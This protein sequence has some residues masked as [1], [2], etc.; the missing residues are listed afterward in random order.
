MTFPGPTA[1][2]K[3]VES[4]MNT[5][6]HDGDQGDTSQGTPPAEAVV[7]NENQAH[8][9]GKHPRQKKSKARKFIRKG[10]TAYKVASIVIQLFTLA[11]ILV[12]TGVTYRMWNVGRV[13][14]QRSAEALNLAKE[15]F[16]ISQSRAGF[17][18]AIDQTRFSEQLN[19]SEKQA[20]TSR[21]QNA[22]DAA[23]SLKLASKSLDES[24][25]A[26]GVSQRARLAAISYG[27]FP[28]VAGVE[29]EASVGIRNSGPVPATNVDA[30][31]TWEI[32]RDSIPDNWAPKIGIRPSSL[33]LVVSPGEPTRIFGLPIPALREE[34]VK[35]I[36]EGTKFLYFFGRFAYNDG[37]G[38]TRQLI[39]CGVHRQTGN[40]WDTCPNNNYA[41]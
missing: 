29:R 3:Q 38:V 39:F 14:N 34:E 18:A 8:E 31:F 7:V 24:R 26:L 9:D 21:K 23:A 40:A 27:E 13:A 22:A 12:Y 20:E 10:W 11:V 2:E 35:S 32:R 6:S 1:E 25:R 4:K 41:D 15:Q 16:A 30:I 19:A 17:D 5:D 28:L 37:F 33:R 36:G